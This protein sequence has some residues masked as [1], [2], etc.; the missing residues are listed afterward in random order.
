M[1]DPFGNFDTAGYLHNVRQ[2]KDQSVIKQ[3][4]HV[5]FRSNLDTALAYLAAREKLSYQDFLVVHRILFSDYY[6]WA[7]QDRA[8]TMPNSAV[9]KGDILFSHPLG[10]L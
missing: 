2:D 5:L 10:K 3:F 7:G 9:K 8:T 1:F 4:E 6:P